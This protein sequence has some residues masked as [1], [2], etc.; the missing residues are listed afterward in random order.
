MVVRAQDG[1]PCSSAEPESNQSS[2]ESVDALAQVRL[3]QANGSAYDGP[4]FRIIASALIEHLDQPHALLIAHSSTLRLS[5]GC[6][7][8]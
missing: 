2:G 3:A 7:L 8:R 6:W 5:T 4:V 1:D